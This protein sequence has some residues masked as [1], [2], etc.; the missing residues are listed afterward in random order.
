MSD[1][2]EDQPYVRLDYENVP[3]GKEIGVAG[4]PLPNLI[5]IDKKL[6]YDG[7]IYRVAK[8]TV[9]AT[10]VTNIATDQGSTLPSIPVIEVNFLFVPG[11]SGG[12][13]FSS[14]TGRVVGFVHGYTAPKIRERIETITLVKEVPKELGT[15][16][17][18]TLNAIYSIGIKLDTARPHIEKFGVSL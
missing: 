2:R 8:G 3:L 1:R 10:Y 11:N 16:Y 15:S 18:G 7:L 5:V 12:P 4:Y 9:T 6:H 13:I 14:E 17:V